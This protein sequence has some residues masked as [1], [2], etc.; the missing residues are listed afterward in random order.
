MHILKMKKRIIRED[1][2]RFYSGTQ[3]ELPTNVKN[4]SI[5]RGRI[6]HVRKDRTTFQT[7]ATL[8]PLKNANGQVIGTIHT[9]KNLTEIVRDIRA[10]QQ[11]NVCNIEAKT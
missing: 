6:T 7:L 1:I 3:L 9:A 4:E 10:T 5:F 2:T 8:S 11:H